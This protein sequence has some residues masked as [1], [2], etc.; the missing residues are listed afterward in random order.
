MEDVKVSYDK[1]K[2]DIN[3]REFHVRDMTNRQLLNTIKRLRRSAANASELKVNNLKDTDLSI[4][5][6]DEYLESTVPQYE[7]ML[8]EVFRRGLSDSELIEPTKYAPA[9][10]S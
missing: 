5:T 9:L 10:V 8:F 3:G 7:T 6:L 2:F 1:F 4:Q